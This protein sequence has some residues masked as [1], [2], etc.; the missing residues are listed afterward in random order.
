MGNPPSQQLFSLFM[1]RA[2][3]PT[4]SRANA[5]PGRAAILAST[6]RRAGSPPPQFQAGVIPAQAGIHAREKLTDAAPDDLEARDGS[7]AISGESYPWLVKR[8]IPH[9]LLDPVIGM[10]DALH[11]LFCSRV[12]KNGKEEAFD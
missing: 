11:R 6:G 10:F 7:T 8:I 2:D 1:F 5:R 3:G 4:M 9:C 12:W